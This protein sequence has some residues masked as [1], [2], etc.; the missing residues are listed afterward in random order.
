[1]V[2]NDEVAGLKELLEAKDPKLAGLQQQPAAND[3][4]TP[5]LEQ[6]QDHNSWWHVIV[7]VLLLFS[8]LVVRNPVCKQGGGLRIS[9]AIARGSARS[10]I[11]FTSTTADLHT[12][13]HTF[14]GCAPPSTSSPIWGRCVAPYSQLIN[15]LAPEMAEHE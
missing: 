12:T 4:D 3:D 14:T 6:Q 5:G 15:G 7:M 8:F 2:S 9:K 13:T 11:N 1:M 10:S